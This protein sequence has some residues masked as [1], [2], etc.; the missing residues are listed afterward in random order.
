MKTLL[1]PLLLFVSSVCYSQLDDKFYQPGKI[2]KPITAVSYTEF[3]IPVEKDTITGIFMNPK[4]KAKATFLFFH[5]SGGNVSTYA[6]MTQPLIEAGY[7]VLM[8]DFRGYGKSTGQPTH[9]NIQHD[10]QKFLDYA[11]QMKELAGKK[12]ILYGASMGS[13]IATNLAKNNGKSIHALVLDGTISSLND[14]AIHFAPQQEA[15][16]KSISFPYSAKEDIKGVTLPTLF[17]HSEKDIMIP[18]QQGR[19]VYDNAPGPKV[20]LNY[21]GPHLEAMVHN[22]ARVIEKIDALLQLSK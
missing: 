5:G 10:G 1:L 15:F 9:Q 13:Q 8:V 12:V 14:V 2:M 16:L 19:M 3:S 4:D 11:L 22:K 18:Y 21:D 7:Q 20:F 6:F 17:I